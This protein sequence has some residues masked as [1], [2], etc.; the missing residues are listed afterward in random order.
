VEVQCLFVVTA[1]A[2]AVC[3]VLVCSVQ[4]YLAPLSLSER[5]RMVPLLYPCLMIASSLG[6]GVRLLSVG[7]THNRLGRALVLPVLQTMR[8]GCSPA[9]PP[10]TV[11]L[12]TRCAGMF[13]D[14]VTGRQSGV[15]FQVVVARMELLVQLFTVIT[16]LGWPDTEPPISVVGRVVARPGVNHTVVVVN[17]YTPDARAVGSRLHVLDPEHDLVLLHRTQ[18]HQSLTMMSLEHSRVVFECPMCAR[19]VPPR[20]SPVRKRKVNRGQPSC[21]NQHRSVSA[22]RHRPAGFHRRRCDRGDAV[23]GAPSY[24]STTHVRHSSTA[25]SRLLVRANP[26]S[27][28]RR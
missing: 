23:R 16:L 18:Y 3:P 17:G 12:R 24:V 8:A 6:F 20:W 22:M 19:V 21:G 11:P 26:D 4:R 10:E 7:L 15:P 9:D 27:E 1:C 14:L 2:P 28:F 13:T 5:L 25:D